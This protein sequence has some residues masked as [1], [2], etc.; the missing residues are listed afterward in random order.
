[1]LK[2]CPKKCSG[3]LQEDDYCWNCGSKLVLKDPMRCVCG[4]VFHTLGKFCTACGIDR[5][6]LQSDRDT[7]KVG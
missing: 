7:K 1:M 2:E 5:V 6:K 4:K 3:I